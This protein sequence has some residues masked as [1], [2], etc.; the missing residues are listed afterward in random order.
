MTNQG[1]KDRE[2]DR[3]KPSPICIRDI[4]SKQGRDIDPGKSFS[5]PPEKSWQLD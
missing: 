2:A 5:R 4:G 1:N 3:V